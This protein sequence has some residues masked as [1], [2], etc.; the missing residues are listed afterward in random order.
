MKEYFTEFNYL[1]HQIYKCAHIEHINDE[2][3]SCFY[4]FG[5]NA[6][7]FLEI[8]LYYKYPHRGCTDETL[9]L[10]FG[11]DKV[12]VILTNRI[13]NEFSHGSLDQGSYPIEVPEM[14]Q[15]AQLILSSLRLDTAQYDDLLKS[16][17]CETDVLVEEPSL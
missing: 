6:R 15:V 10:F 11:S 9:E 7:K 14:K 3:F 13:N 4:G 16:V 1:F 17:G 12:P 5:N 2:N 8:F